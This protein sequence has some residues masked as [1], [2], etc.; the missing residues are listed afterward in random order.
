MVSL[1]HDFTVAN[2]RELERRVTSYLLGRR[3]PALRQ[4]AVQADHGTVTLRGEVCSLY[5]KQLCLSCGNCVDGVR[6]L[7]DDI[8]VVAVL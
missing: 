4:I 3:M 6:E 2:D 1:E 8:D 7:V 5:Q